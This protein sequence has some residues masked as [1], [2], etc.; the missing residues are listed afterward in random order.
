MIISNTSAEAKRLALREA[1]SSGKLLQLPGAFNPMVALLIEQKN[2]DGVYVSGAVMA[3]S[4]G[5]PDIGMTTLTEV[6]AFASNIAKVT[7]LPTIMDIDTG[8]GEPMMVARTIKEITYLGLSGCHIEDQINP[9]RCGHLDN[10][11]LVAVDVMQKKIKAAVDAKS[12]PN[13]LLIA[14]TDAKSVEGMEKAID[15]AKAYIDAGAD[16]IFPEALYNEKEFEQFRKAIDVPLLA[17]MTE[18]G[19]S[20]LLTKNQ[21][22]NL[23]Y[24]MVI[25]PVTLQRLAMKAV[26]DG[27]DVITTTGSQESI[28]DKMQTR[29]RLYELLKYEDYNQYDNDIFNFEL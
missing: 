22:E 18:F 27:L 13:F 24:N 15:R 7:S 9:K 14:R 3:N 17:N 1:L 12:D 8:F 11:E 19:K 10:K 20:E 25:Y 5:L 4:L 23:G 2:F 21:L 29:K 16:A 6:A 28:V 26:E